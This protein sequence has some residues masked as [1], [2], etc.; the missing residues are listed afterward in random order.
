M[1]LL[2]GVLG[3]LALLIAKALTRSDESF[4]NE[5]DKPHGSPMSGEGGDW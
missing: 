5:N 3:D 1:E 2:G 4:G